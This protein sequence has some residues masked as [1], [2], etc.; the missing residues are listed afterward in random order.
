L[1][2]R[3]G[4]R[5]FREEKGRCRVAKPPALNATTGPLH[6]AAGAE[7]LRNPDYKLANCGVGSQALDDFKGAVEV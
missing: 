7:L 5:R 3:R 6:E 4:L 1:V 2:W